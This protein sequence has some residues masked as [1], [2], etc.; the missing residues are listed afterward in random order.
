MV[1]SILN[2]WVVQALRKIPI[3]VFPKLLIQR[4][5]KAIVESNFLTLCTVLCVNQNHSNPNEQ[6]HDEQKGWHFTLLMTQ[7]TQRWIYIFLSFGCLSRSVASLWPGCLWSYSSF[8]RIPMFAIL[9]REGPLLL[10][11]A[12]YTAP[13]ET[14]V[15]ASLPQTSKMT[16]FNGFKGEITNLI[17][18]KA[19]APGIHF[20]RIVSKWV[21][22]NTLQLA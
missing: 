2:V 10:S 14:R 20:S 3:F 21:T 9:W 1:L 6:L 19:G 11:I 15:S 8:W 12:R 4:F 18:I 22:V 13:R 16:F 7:L 17:D 5:A